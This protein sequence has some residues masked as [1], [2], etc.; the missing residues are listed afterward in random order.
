MKRM[1]AGSLLLTARFAAADSG[2]STV[3]VEDRIVF[4]VV[5]VAAPV[6]TTFRY[7]SDDKLGAKWLAPRVEIEKKAG[8]KY[9]LFWDPA[10][11]ENDS[12]IG[13]H[14]TAL[15][16]NQLIAFQWRRPSQD[17]DVT[18]VAVSFFAEGTD[19][20]STRVVLIHSGWRN[21]PPSEK[22]RLEREAA[23]RQALKRLVAAASPSI[24]GQPPIAGTCWEFDG[25]SGAV[26][27]P[28]SK[29]VRPSPTLVDFMADGTVHIR[30]NSF[31]P[32]SGRWTQQGDSV[33]FDCN[34]FTQY[35]VLLDGNR[36]QGRWTRRL[37]GHDLGH[38]SETSL[39]YLRAP[40]CPAP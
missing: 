3:P 5:E 25:E 8:G 31:P 18:H 23:W 6:E 19:R 34:G 16:P 36:M 28:V 21:D 33:T 9:E 17:K 4:E 27:L 38:S 30:N 10:S 14:L 11:R 7:F 2:N 37:R 22:A 13:C 15:M 29:V 26:A 12:T 20:K 40:G 39:H 35:Q 1:I 24:P 32:C